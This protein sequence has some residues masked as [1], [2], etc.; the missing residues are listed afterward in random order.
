MKGTVCFE[1]T[2]FS[3]DYFHFTILIYIILS[4]MELPFLLVKIYQMSA[5]WCRSAQ[6]RGQRGRWLYLWYVMAVLWFD[7][8]GHSYP[9]LKSFESMVEVQKYMYQFSYRKYSDS[10]NNVLY[11]SSNNSWAYK[12]KLILLYSNK[13]PIL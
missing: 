10:T 1:F 7:I 6:W 11:N 9:D 4:Q 3:V 2:V 13:G 8:W 12:G 5:I